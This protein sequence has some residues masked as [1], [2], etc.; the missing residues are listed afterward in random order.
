[1][2]GRT[3]LAWRSLSNYSCK[4]GAL[5]GVPTGEIRVRRWAGGGGRKGDKGAY[6]ARVQRDDAAQ[7]ERGEPE[8]LRD[9]EVTLSDA[10]KKG[11]QKVEGKRVEGEGGGGRRRVVGG[12]AGQEGGGGRG[13]GRER[14][15]IHVSVFAE[16]R[17]R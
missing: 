13:G 4:Q 10:R 15:M 14:H 6:L 8:R 12:G 9:E 1:M 17:D 7:E 2:Q 5:F 16:K 11:R 3:S